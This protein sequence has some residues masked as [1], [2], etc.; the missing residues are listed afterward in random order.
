MVDVDFEND[1][2]K[3]GA[4]LGEM[5]KRNSGYD[6]YEIMEVDGIGA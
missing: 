1:V 5:D 6:D 2:E 3:N 4:H